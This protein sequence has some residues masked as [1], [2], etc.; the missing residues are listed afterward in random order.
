MEEAKNRAMAV[1]ETFRNVILMSGPEKILAG[2]TMA[3]REAADG[4]DFLN[5]AGRYLGCPAF[6][7]SGEDEAALS[8][9]GVLS[10]LD[11]VPREG[12]VIDIGGRSTEL[13]NTADKEIVFTQSLPVGVVGLTEAHIREDVP[14][15]FEMEAVRL[16]VERAL[17]SASWERLG[18]NPTLVG[19]AGTVTTIAA[20][21]L[22]LDLYLPELINN[23]TFGKGQIEDLLSA[24]SKLTSS[25]RAEL[26]GL[27][28]RRADVIIAGLIE[29]LE[30]MDFLG[31]DSLT[32]SDN[33][34][35]EGL[36]LAEAGLSDHALASSTEVAP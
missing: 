3:F 31:K 35:L 5:M 12:L 29:A 14:A 7:L 28:P 1:L 20:M 15:P 6:V 16:S 22:K 26:P 18:S 9:E 32:V 21:L 2:G 36:W 33:S 19:T 8:A 11:P 30:I 17:K 24:L 4:A 13:I 25:Q 34:L 23:Q 27:H 10:G